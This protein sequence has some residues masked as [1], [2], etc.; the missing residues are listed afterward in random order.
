MNIRILI[1]YLYVTYVLE[2]SS[3]DFMRRLWIQKCEVEASAAT[4][5][6]FKKEEPS[7]GLFL[8]PLMEKDHTAGLEEIDLSLCE[9]IVDLKHITVLHNE[10]EEIQSI[11]LP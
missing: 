6:K 8:L 5:Y 11:S 9:G 2:N 4:R 1:A 10:F 7:E 3:S